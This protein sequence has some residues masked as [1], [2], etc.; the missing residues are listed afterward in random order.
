[1]GKFFLE[2]IFV[3]L[4]VCLCLFLWLIAIMFPPIVVVR[5]LGELDLCYLALRAE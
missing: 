4:Y 5:V 2:V 1:M 3:C